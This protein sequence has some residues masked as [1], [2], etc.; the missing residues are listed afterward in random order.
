MGHDPALDSPYPGLFRLKMARFYDVVASAKKNK[1]A[2]EGRR[3]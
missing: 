3:L 2:K 1:R